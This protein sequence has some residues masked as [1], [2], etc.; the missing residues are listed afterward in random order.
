MVNQCKGH[1][2]DASG[3]A[4]TEYLLLLAIIIS[5]GLVVRGFVR[6]FQVA[7]LLLRP[8][9]KTFAY[10]YLYGHPKARGMNDGGPKYHPRAI[11]TGENNFRL[12]MNPKR[13]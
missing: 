10:V 4:I 2:K 3:Q 7:D 8:I 6:R 13:R 5:L 11:G 9:N 12:F 1:Q